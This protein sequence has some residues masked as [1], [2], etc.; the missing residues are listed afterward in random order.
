MFKKE[1]NIWGRQGCE[2]ASGN[3]CTA[4]CTTLEIPELTKGAGHLCAHQTPCQGCKIKD[5]PGRPKRCNDYHC[6][7]EHR[8]Q[9]I[10][11][12]TGAALING[13][14]TQAQAVETQRRLLG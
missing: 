7:T 14:V 3:L 12:L 4:C 8:P 13:E 1:L 5:L 6:S 11:Y 2:L 9:V 10:F